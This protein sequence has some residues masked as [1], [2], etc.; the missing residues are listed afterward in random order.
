MTSCDLPL[1]FHDFADKGTSRMRN[2]MLLLCSI[3]PGHPSL[4]LTLLYLAS[5]NGSTQIEGSHSSTAGDISPLYY[6]WETSVFKCIRSPAATVTQNYIVC[7]TTVCHPCKNRQK[8]FPMR[9]DK[10]RSCLFKSTPLP[11]RKKKKKDEIA[12]P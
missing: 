2:K 9:S 1:V 6:R 10:N 8:T 5:E 11:T 12:N 7:R 4:L 3:L